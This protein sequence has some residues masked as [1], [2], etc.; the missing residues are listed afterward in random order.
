MTERGKSGSIDLPPFH[1]RAVMRVV[2]SVSNS[3]TPLSVEGKEP[4]SRDRALGG[5]WG[6]DPRTTSAAAGSD[7]AAYAAGD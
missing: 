1:A 7:G 6:G 2:S 3:G 5:V 4:G